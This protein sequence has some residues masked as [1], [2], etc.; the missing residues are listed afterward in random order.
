MIH[1]EE[2][3]NDIVSEY[4]DEKLSHVLVSQT[5]DEIGIDSLSL[6]EI[7]F[8]I[9]EAFDIKIPDDNVLNEKGYSL[10]GYADILALVE[11]LVEERQANV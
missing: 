3:L 6:V 8:D 5:L 2:K 9:E 11:S 1:I 10:S 4:T 7:I